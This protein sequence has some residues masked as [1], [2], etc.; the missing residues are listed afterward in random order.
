MILILAPELLANVRDAASASYGEECCGL[1]LGH[2]DGDTAKVTA[3]M[4][5]ENV[6]PEK[7]RNFE[8]DPAILFAA[9]KSAR[10]GG[11]GI[12]GNYHSHPNGLARPSKTD[13]ARAFEDNHFW[14]IV[15]ID[16]GGVGDAKAFYHRSGAFEEA[17]LEVANG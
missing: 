10:D 15:P 12:I 7:T 8:I 4:A 6:A 14:L 16:D 17:T 2:L 5:A 13:G 3:V 9:H 11:A 1:L